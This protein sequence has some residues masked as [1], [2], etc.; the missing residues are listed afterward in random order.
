MTLIIGDQ[1]FS[2]CVTSKAVASIQM[3]TS[4]YTV[5]QIKSMPALDKASAHLNFEY[6][7]QRAFKLNFE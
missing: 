6:D 7:D 4:K 3:C 2:A 1:Q 5:H